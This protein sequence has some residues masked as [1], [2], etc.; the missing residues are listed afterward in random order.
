M[1]LAD[2]LVLM[3]AI[4]SLGAIMLVGFALWIRSRERGG[5]ADV[6]ASLRYRLH[7]AFNEYAKGI[8]TSIIGGLIFLAMLPT[9][10]FL[11]AGIS[12]ISVLVIL[13]FWTGAIGV[14]WET[15]NE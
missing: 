14:K 9:S 3:C 11:A 10:P 6:Y 7:A 5:L 15:K 4:L 8:T 2:G 1:S 12:T 13:A